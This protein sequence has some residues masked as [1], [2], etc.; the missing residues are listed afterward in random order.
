MSPSLDVVLS[1]G[2]YNDWNKKGKDQNWG[3]PSWGEAHVWS[4][5]FSRK[6]VSSEGMHTID[7]SVWMCIHS[8]RVVKQGGP[9]S[10]HPHLQGL[11]ISAHEFLVCTDHLGHHCGLLKATNASEGVLWVCIWRNNWGLGKGVESRKG[12]K[13]TRRQKEEP[14][15]GFQQG[16]TWEIELVGLLKAL[17]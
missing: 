12:K 5:G 7:Q 14:S 16:N 3:I 1:W 4:S 2:F 8:R 15:R 17:M 6:S 11:R 13:T 9:G 10:E